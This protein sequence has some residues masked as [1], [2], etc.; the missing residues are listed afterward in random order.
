MITVLIKDSSGNEMGKFTAKAEGNLLDQ[1]A[2]HNIELPFSCHAG[3][4][5]SC[6]AR[7]LSG[8]EYIDEEKDGPKYI[9]TDDDVILTCIGGVDAEKAAAGEEYVI[10]IEVL[11]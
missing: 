9:D 8:H 5:M 7:V 4:C 2:E 11:N 3:A 1:A 6:S 10:E